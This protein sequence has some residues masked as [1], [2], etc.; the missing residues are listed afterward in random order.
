M[1]KPKNWLGIILIATAPLF[2]H[3]S[4]F[5]NR[6]VKQ[7]L[8]KA[9]AHYNEGRFATA[10]TILNKTL[11]QQ[12]DNYKSVAWYLLMKA[13]YGLNKMEESRGMARNILQSDPQSTY[14]KHVFSCLGDMFVDEGKYSAA[15]R[16]YLR[17]RALQ[18]DELFLEKIDQRIMNTLKVNI[19]L[20]RV[21]EMLSVEFDLQN[22]SILL[23][24]KAYGAIYAGQPDEGAQTL[25]GINLDNVPNRYF[26]FYE[27]LLLATYHPPKKNI[28]IGVVLPLSGEYHSQ[29]NLFLEGLKS[30]IQ[31][32]PDELHNLSLVIYDNRS[33]GIETIRAVKVLAKRQEIVAIVGPLNT[34][35]AL[36]AA[37]SLSGSIIPLLIPSSVQNG[38]VTL[39]ENI[40]QLNSD[41][42]TRGRFA[43]RYAVQKLGLK[44]IAVL[45]PANEMGHNL[46]DSF[47]KE[48]DLLG[49]IPVKLEWYSDVPEDLRRQFKSIRKTAWDLMPKEDEYSEFLGLEI[50]SLDA[51]FTISVDDFFDLP[52]DQEKVLSS[53]DSSKISLDTIDGIYLPISPNHLS[54]LATQFPLYNLNTQVIGNEAWQN[55][56]IL[57]QENI[58][59]H[60]SRMI[61]I[62][63]RKEFVQNELPVQA[64]H[65]KNNEFFFQGFDCVQLLSAV[66]NEDNL[67]RKTI[68][69]RLNSIE[70]FHGMGRIF[71]FSGEPSNLNKAL[72]VLQYDQNNFSSLGFFKGD[73]LITS[74]FQAP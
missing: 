2:A 40:L 7:Q 73:S 51:L 49:Q 12:G 9:V 17:A 32:Q 61:V 74:F 15:L 39:G 19:S 38:L 3:Q 45:A 1:N 18:S 6:S 28:T 42:N 10:K 64:D 16:M 30:A 58:G 31:S 27:E 43:A 69:E 53:K 55:L 54:Y 47:C 67:D 29:G 13:N 70:E 5:E 59:P 36:I 37:N 4:W 46:V 48:L 62:S 72:Q 23:L 22:R 63:N 11:K 57:N 24:T 25:S 14:V 21:D 35:N 44:N 60:L 50:D 56:E 52:K 26:D 34:G 68:L 8:K 20:P 41:E 33:K 71:S 66:I 65:H